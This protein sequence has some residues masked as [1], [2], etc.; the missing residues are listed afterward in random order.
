MKCKNCNKKNGEKYSKYSSGEF[1]SKKC[2]KSYSVKIRNKKE[3]KIEVFCISC[4]KF[5][6]KTTKGKSINY[7]FCPDCH[8]L[9]QNITLFKKLEV[10]E[11]NLQIS[12]EKALKVLT[13]E[14][15]TNKL[16]LIQIKEKYEIMFNTVHFFFKKNGIDLRNFSNAQKLA[17]KTGRKITPLNPKFE[18]GYHITWY[19]KKIFYRSSYER[20]MMEILDSK[21][22]IYFYE[23]LKI[24]Y[25]FKGEKNVHITDFYLPEKNLVIE[26][27]GEWFQK[28]DEEK[29]E[30]KKNAILLEGY[31]HIIIGK[32]ELEQYEKEIKI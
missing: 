3:E 32:K 27:K 1:C 10:L 6:K 30:A 21:R 11:N 26:T 14:Y 23:T 4:G 22:E 25:D 29:I 16:G 19:G 31:Y 12:N 7:K 13:K 8:K 5:I 28:R 2:A 18:T 15:F 17:I 24:E 9:K 20:R